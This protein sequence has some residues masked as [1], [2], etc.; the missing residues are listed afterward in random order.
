VQRFV[1][2]DPLSELDPEG[3]IWALYSG[4]RVHSTIGNPIFLAAY[5]TLMMGAAAALYFEARSQWER[6]FC[7]STL[8]AIG[9]CWFY[10]YTLGAMLGTGIALAIVLWVARRRMGT[11][12]PLLVPLTTLMVAVLVAAGLG[13]FYD[14]YIATKTQDVTHSQAARARFLIWRD[15]IPMI[16][17]RPLLGYG[18]DNF[19][20][21]FTSYEGEDLKLIAESAPVDRAHNESLDVAATTGV[22][23][24]AA[25]VW[26]FAVYFREAY[27]RGGWTLISLSGGVLAY[28]LQL[29]TIFTTLPTGITFWALLGVSSAL[30]RLSADRQAPLKPARQIAEATTSAAIGS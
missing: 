27:R 4:T 26:I 7:I 17:E 5:L 19:A 10:T 3:G 13:A 15:T 2:F 25:Y 14:G 20:T 22:A 30:M 11:V 12:R 8:A 18:P 24:L 21:P 9:A 29:Q 6:V 16:L 23:G 1:G 28:I